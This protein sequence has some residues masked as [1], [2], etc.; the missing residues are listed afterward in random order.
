MHSAVIVCSDVWANKPVHV[1]SILILVLILIL[2][3]HPGSI[4]PGAC[5]ARELE[6]MDK[7]DNLCGSN[8]AIDTLRAAPFNLIAR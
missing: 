8:V 7:D 4:H 6:L 1:P 2:S 5:L 3:G